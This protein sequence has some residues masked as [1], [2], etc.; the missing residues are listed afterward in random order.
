MAGKQT[1]DIPK[2]V[3][4]SIVN[5]DTGDQI[6]LQFEPAVLSGAVSANYNSDPAIGG[7]H[8]N[9]MFSHTSNETFALEM[10]WHRVMLTA[11]TGKS[12][13]RADKIIENHRAFIRALLSPIGITED[14]IGGEAP[15]VNIN[16]PGVF[17]VMARLINIDWD[18]P[19]RDPQTGSI[20][21]LTMRCTF[22]EDPKYRYSSA[23]I[24]NA[25]YE[26]I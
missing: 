5:L 25:G 14:I 1:Y 12:T 13:D 2:G 24:F 11:L 10:R 7:T 3:R 17:N 20:M 21:E 18:V 4:T 8:E 22:K 26:R 16:V 6:Y 9:M 23:D 19:R 15:L